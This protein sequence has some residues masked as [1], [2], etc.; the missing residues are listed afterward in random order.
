MG[1]SNHNKRQPMGTQEMEIAIKC[2]KSVSLCSFSILF[3]WVSHWG[4]GRVLNTCWTNSSAIAGWIRGPQPS[5]TP[6]GHPVLSSCKLFTQHVSVSGVAAAVELGQWLE[7]GGERVG[8]RH[9]CP[10]LPPALSH[11]WKAPDFRVP[12]APGFQLSGTAE[13][14]II[15]I[16]NLVKSDKNIWLPS[17]RSPPFSRLIDKESKFNQ[18]TLKWK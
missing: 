17:L 9:H 1:H 8:S 12:P 18:T 7:V 10:P 5:L 13:A 2:E 6:Q 4:E 11:Y 14:V 15:N 3:I 16:I